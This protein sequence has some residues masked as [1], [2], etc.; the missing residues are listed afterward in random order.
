MGRFPRLCASLTE[1]C[2]AI[3]AVGIDAPLV[4]RIRPFTAP[5]LIWNTYTALDVPL[6]DGGKA[7]TAPLDWDARN[8]VRFRLGLARGRSL[9][10]IV[11]YPILAASIVSASATFSFTA[12]HFVGAFL[13]A[14]S[15]LVLAWVVQSLPD[16]VADHGSA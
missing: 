4:R 13:I 10:G 8:F 2:Q 15:A 16:G 7:L 11:T 3:R 5:P 6:L 14:A 9:V 12:P 1:V